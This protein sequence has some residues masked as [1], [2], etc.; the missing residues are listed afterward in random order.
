[1]GQ[2]RQRRDVGHLERGVGDALHVEHLGLR[3][4]RRLE[5]L[6][7]RG[8]H[9]GG[10][11]VHRRQQVGEQ[12]VGAAVD[13]VAGHDVVAAAAELQQRARDGRH[14]RG[15]AERELGRLHRGHVARQHVEGRVEVAAVEEAAALVGPAQPLEDLRHDAGLHHGEGGRAGQ[16]GADAPMLAELALGVPQGLDRIVFCGHGVPLPLR[17]FGRSLPGSDLEVS[18]LFFGLEGRWG[19]ALSP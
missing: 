13:R 12:R 15:G 17:L 2:A 9:E 14:A 7:V 8:V 4:D 3:A 16:R 5:A 10:L 6:G 11:D 1:M 18:C 19:R